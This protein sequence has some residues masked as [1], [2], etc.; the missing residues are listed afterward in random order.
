MSNRFALLLLWLAAAPVAAQERLPVLGFAGGLATLSPP[1]LTWGHVC[2]GVHLFAI[3]ATVPAAV[4]AVEG[5]G[6]STVS[7]GS[8]SGRCDEPDATETAR[9][10]VHDVSQ[11]GR[12]LQVRV[13]VQAFP[14]AGQLDGRLRVFVKGEPPLDMPIH[15]QASA[16]NP[17]FQA[18]AWFLG[19]AIPGALTY[20]LGR[21]A[22]DAQKRSEEL[23]AQ[24]TRFRRY[25]SDHRPE[26]D[27]LF[28]QFVPELCRDEQNAVDWTRKLRAKLDEHLSVIP[29]EQQEALVA[30]LNTAR[31]ADV[32]AILASLYSEWKGQ[33]ASCR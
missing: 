30:A 12:W 22:F 31:R 24:R 25:V 2:F 5:L 20:F 3:S 16:S 27:T 19:I 26:L 23:A 15:L 13:P 21:L 14:K 7:D 29:L 18:I 17:F 8:W 9:L 28:V 11:S 6:A 32:I 4:V 33:I 10:D 1:A